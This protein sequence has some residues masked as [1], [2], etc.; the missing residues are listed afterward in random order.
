LVT[1]F[2]NPCVSET[3]S[4]WSRSVTGF[5]IWVEKRAPGLSAA[6]LADRELENPVKI[7]D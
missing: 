6:S 3:S 1:L 2:S 5:V 7:P 4:S